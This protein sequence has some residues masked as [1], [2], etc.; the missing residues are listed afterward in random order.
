M[1]HQNLQKRSAEEDR[2]VESDTFCNCKVDRFHNKKRCCEK[3]RDIGAIK[4]QVTFRCSLSISLPVLFVWQNDE[5]EHYV[6]DPKVTVAVYKLSEFLKSVR[7][8]LTR[9]SV[10]SI[11]S[12]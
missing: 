4:L 12:Q 3:I 8:D 9:R 10:G 5:G 2:R 7:E 1:Y 6:G 11:G